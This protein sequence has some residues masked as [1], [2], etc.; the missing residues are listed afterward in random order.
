MPGY[1]EEEGKK[2]MKFGDCLA[3]STKGSSRSSG[4]SPMC[5][6]RHYLCLD[7]LLDVCPWFSILWGAAG[8]KW[9]QVTGF[10]V[11]DDS[12]T[13]NCGIVIDN[14]IISVYLVV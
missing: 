12:A 10:N 2:A 6:S 3:Q 14:W 8:K 11:G 1:E 7:V 9:L 13:C 5:E 4:I